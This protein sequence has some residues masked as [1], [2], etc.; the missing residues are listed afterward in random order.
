MPAVPLGTRAW[1]FEDLP[2]AGEAGK[3]SAKAASRA[4]KSTAEHWFSNAS[5]ASSASAAATSRASASALW[6]PMR[7]SCLPHHA[8]TRART[9]HVRSSSASST[10][11]STASIAS[12]RSWTE[13]DHD[14]ATRIAPRSRP[15]ASAAATS[16]S[17]LEAVPS[18]P[19]GLLGGACAML[20]APP[21]PSFFLRSC[22]RC[23]AASKRSWPRSAPDDAGRQS[24]DLEPRS[25]QPH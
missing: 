3:A 6:R 16:I 24:E 9:S 20:K 5:C 22:W 2:V 19:K 18:K 21:P 8:C 4:S 1:E 10:V 17:G 11:L 25:R 23:L 15:A 14:I 13:A 12:R 7:S